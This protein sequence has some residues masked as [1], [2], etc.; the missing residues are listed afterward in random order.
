[1]VLKRGLRP[2]DY[3]SHF[4]ELKGRISGMSHHPDNESQEMSLTRKDG[5]KRSSRRTT[6]NASTTNENKTKGLD[7]TGRGTK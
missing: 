1:L 7:V 4:E 6:S 3:P 5:E 2:E